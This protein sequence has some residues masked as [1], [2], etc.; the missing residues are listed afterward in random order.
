MDLPYIDFP[1]GPHATVPPAFGSTYQEQ[2]LFSVAGNADGSILLAMRGTY[3][4]RPVIS[5]DFGVSWQGVDGVVFGV[6]EVPRGTID[7]W[8]DKAE[9]RFVAT[10]LLQVDDFADVDGEGFSGWGDPTTYW[11][12][13]AD[14]L[15]WQKQAGAAPIGPGKGGTHIVTAVPGGFLRTLRPF[16]DTGWPFESSLGLPEPPAFSQNG[17]DWVTVNL[18]DTTIADSEGAL[19]IGNGFIGRFAELPGGK[20]YI[21]GAGEDVYTSWHGV[22]EFYLGVPITPLFWTDFVKTVE[23][24]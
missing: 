14:G 4:Y 1:G 15:M 13:S 18:P 6:N 5:L 8:F 10:G 7:L 20:Y 23:Y 2:S 3:D 11:M 22:V 16:L 9:G 12:T 21:C 17:E 19:A 24:A